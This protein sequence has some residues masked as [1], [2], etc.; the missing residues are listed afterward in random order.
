MYSIDID[1]RAKI[2]EG[3]KI[4]HCVGLVIGSKVKIGKNCTLF[5]NTTLGLKFSKYDDGMPEIGDNVFI[6]TGTILL[7]SIKISDNSKIKAGTVM[8]SERK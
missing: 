3:L 4:Y 2:D 5:H 6:G 7:G 1:Y 8:I